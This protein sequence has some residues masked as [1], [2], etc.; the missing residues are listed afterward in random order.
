[1]R[2]MRGDTRDCGGR[3]ETAEQ[4]GVGAGQSG[5]PRAPTGSVYASA[6]DPSATGRPE[7]ILAAAADSTCVYL[8]RD[9]SKD[10]SGGTGRAAQFSR[11]QG[12]MKKSRLRVYRSVE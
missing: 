7:S 12:H 5:T 10:G 9:F 11:V 8:Q 4:Q 3:A 2:K 1:M 6:M